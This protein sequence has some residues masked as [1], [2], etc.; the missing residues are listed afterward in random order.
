MPECA[1]TPGCIFFNDKMADM[2]AMSSM[3]KNIYCKDKFETCARFQ[4]VQAVGREK[5]PADLFP[6]QLDRAVAVIKLG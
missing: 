6:N 4:V 5:V 2:P 1:L 3:M